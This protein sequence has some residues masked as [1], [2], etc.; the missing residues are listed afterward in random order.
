VFKL[1]QKYPGPNFNKN[2]FVNTICSHLQS[3]TSQQ[4]Q[5]VQL[6]ILRTWLSAFTI[7]SISL[8]LCIGHVSPLFQRLFLFYSLT[9][10]HHFL[11]KSSS[12]AM[13]SNKTMMSPSKAQLVN[14]H[15]ITQA[16]THIFM[17]LFHQDPQSIR[18]SIKLCYHL[19]LTLTI[20]WPSFSRAFLLSHLNFTGQLQWTNVQ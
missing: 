16:C 20:C 8:L 18:T 6:T 9:F 13:Y 12:S 5:V 3:P 1:F 11:L 4:G 17:G 19:S 15:I 10:W 7:L 2:S 14:K